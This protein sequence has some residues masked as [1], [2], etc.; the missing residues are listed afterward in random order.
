[1]ENDF[2]LKSCS[3]QGRDIMIPTLSAPFQVP[4]VSILVG[5][6][7]PGHIQVGWTVGEADEL[8]QDSCAKKR[9]RLV[10]EVDR[11]SGKE[12]PSHGLASPDPEG[13][14]PSGP[15]RAEAGNNSLKMEQIMST[16]VQE[17]Q[18]IKSQ[19]SR[20]LA[21]TTAQLDVLGRSMGSS[22]GCRLCGQQQLAE[23]SRVWR[24]FSCDL[25]D[26]ESQ[27]PRPWE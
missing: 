6:F 21:D 4:V 9:T 18:D 25:S 7:T 26:E 1:M 12:A 13:A 23:G 22:S 5:G 14:A 20:F 11:D 19:L 2:K 8:Q 24:Q 10:S 16:L 17:L 3:Y 27:V 15:P